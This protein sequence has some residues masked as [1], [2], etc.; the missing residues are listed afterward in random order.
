M[1]SV[2]QVYAQGYRNVCDLVSSCELRQRAS[3]LKAAVT[4]FFS[5][6]ASQ[7]SKGVNALIWG[8]SDLIA[9]TAPFWI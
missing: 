1:F 5:F 4:P 6:N 8:D 2:Q 7:I 3:R 9:D